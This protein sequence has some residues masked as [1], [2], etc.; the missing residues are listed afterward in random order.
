VERKRKGF[1]EEEDIKRKGGWGKHVRDRIRMI[2]KEI[3]DRRNM[4]IEEIRIEIR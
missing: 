4:C 1:K 2:K 3:C